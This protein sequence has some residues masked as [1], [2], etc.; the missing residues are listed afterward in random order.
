MLLSPTFIRRRR[1]RRVKIDARCL[2][3]RVLAVRRYVEIERATRK[4]GRFDC[5]RRCWRFLRSSRRLAASPLAHNEDEQMNDR[6]REHC[7]CAVVVATAAATATTSVD[8]AM[9]DENMSAR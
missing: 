3:G 9:R 4:I 6:R 1:E 8:D 2:D 5:R 7:E